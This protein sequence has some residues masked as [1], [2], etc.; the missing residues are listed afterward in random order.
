MTIDGTDSVVK[1]E[2]LRKSNRIRSEGSKIHRG[3][4][5]SFYQKNN[6]IL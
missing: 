3:M 2:I 1:G 4:L 5:R 6:S